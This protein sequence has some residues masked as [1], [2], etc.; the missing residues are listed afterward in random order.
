MTTKIITT[1][2]EKKL[3]IEVKEREFI[4]VKTIHTTTINYRS[5]KNTYFKKTCKTNKLRDNLLYII[6]NSMFLE[7]QIKDFLN[8]SNQIDEE[9][10]KLAKT[11]TYLIKLEENF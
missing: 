11:G 1:D 8:Y 10:N 6:D 9:L 7:L 2:T 5:H 3:Y 4:I